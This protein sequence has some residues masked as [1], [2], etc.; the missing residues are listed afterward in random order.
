MTDKKPYDEHTVWQNVGTS[1][2][3][4]YQ[5]GKKRPTIVAPGE[6]YKGNVPRHLIRNGSF[7]PKAKKKKDDDS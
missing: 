2:V 6:T 3:A 4:I 1:T 5:P 7:R